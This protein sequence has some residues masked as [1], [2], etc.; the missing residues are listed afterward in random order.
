[1]HSVGDI[2]PPDYIDLYEVMRRMEYFQIM[3][4]TTNMF[5]DAM[6][7]ATPHHTDLKKN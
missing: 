7:N 4:H 2:P 5:P 3:L 6:Y 1:M